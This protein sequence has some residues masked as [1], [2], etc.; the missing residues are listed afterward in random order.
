MAGRDEKAGVEQSRV[1]V[2]EEETGKTA[3]M[4]TIPAPG[5]TEG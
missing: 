4:E 2:R 5:T 1:E 3:G